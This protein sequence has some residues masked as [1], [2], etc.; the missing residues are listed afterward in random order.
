MSARWYAAYLAVL[1]AVFV[2]LWLFA[3]ISHWPR[4]AFACVAGATAAAGSEAASR[5]TPRKRSRG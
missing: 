4:W 1:A 5:I 2:P 3:G